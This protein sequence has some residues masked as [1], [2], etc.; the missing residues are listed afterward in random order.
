M[1]TLEKR[2]TIPDIK[3]RNRED[4]HIPQSPLPELTEEEEKFWEYR[5]VPGMI[6]FLNRMEKDENKLTERIRK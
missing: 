4:S 6:G 5:S 2:L 3:H 1:K